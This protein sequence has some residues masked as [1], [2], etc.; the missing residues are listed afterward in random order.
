MWE[1]KIALER[2]EIGLESALSNKLGL[3]NA[4]KRKMIGLKSA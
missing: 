2:K 3:E 1:I 4:F